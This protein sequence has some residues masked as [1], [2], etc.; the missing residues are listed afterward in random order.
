M[1]IIMDT[2]VILIP[3]DLQVDPIRSRVFPWVIDGWFQMT[4]MVKSSTGRIWCI[5]N[6]TKPY[7]RWIVGKWL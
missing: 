2:S 1:K 6:Y 3:S 4:S 5:W 7:L